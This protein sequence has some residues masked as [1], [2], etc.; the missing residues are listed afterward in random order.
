M[1]HSIGCFYSHFSS[2]IGHHRI[3]DGI[4]QSSI[5]T[6][7]EHEHIQ[8]ERQLPDRMNNALEQQCI[9]F[10]CNGT[11][12]IL[13]ASSQFNDFPSF[14]Y[15][16]SAM[17][18]FFLF[19]EHS[20]H[21]PSFAVSL[22]HSTRII[23]AQSVYLLG[24]NLLDALFFWIRMYQSSGVFQSFAYA[25]TRHSSFNIQTSIKY[26][27]FLR[28]LSKIVMILRMNISRSEERFC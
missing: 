6:V 4:R 10:S 24:K 11:H 27:V 9:H 2:R 8:R 19:D 14:C 22:A 21:P 7:N 26:R 13:K 25:Y 12:G 3:D 1:Q 16:H 23:F 5:C 15:I 17:F 20:T 18:S 28:I